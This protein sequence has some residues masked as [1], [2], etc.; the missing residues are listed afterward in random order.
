[1]AMKQLRASKISQEYLRDFKSS[2]Y[3]SLLFVEKNTVKLIVM[4]SG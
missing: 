1:M 4:V 3:L 2:E